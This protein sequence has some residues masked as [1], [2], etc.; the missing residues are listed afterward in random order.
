MEKNEFLEELRKRLKGLSKED[1][2]ERIAYYGEMIDDRIEDG[3]TEK[4]AVSDIG[5]IDDV[6]TDIAKETPMTSLIKE[7]VKPKRRLYG[8]EILV[9][10]LGFP[11]W[12]PL[13]IVGLVLFLVALFVLLILQFAFYIVDASL[14]GASVFSIIIFF[15]AMVDGKFSMM[16]LGFGVAGIGVGLLLVLVSALSTKIVAKITKRNIIG[17]KI[18]F[19]KGGQ[20]E[21]AC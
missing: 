19:I 6:I 14:L 8:W 16:Y 18:W 3:K 11:L 5:E 2:E 21:K 12:F 4:E 1:L 13:V 7:R 10:I 9:L 20:N 15:M 17:V